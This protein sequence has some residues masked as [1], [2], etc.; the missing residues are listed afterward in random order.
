MEAYI[1]IGRVNR[2]LLDKE[3]SAVTETLAAIGISSNIFVDRY[4]FRAD[5]EKDMM[6]R[7]MSEIDRCDLFIAE[8]SEKGIGVGVETGYA[9]AHNKTILYLRHADVEHST[10]VSG[11]SDYHVFYRDAGALKLKLEKIV[12]QW[13][14]ERN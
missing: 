2:N 13:R 8:V 1:S 11:V 10:T 3:I 7:A 6:A 12:T 4:S 5:Q 9:R 14:A